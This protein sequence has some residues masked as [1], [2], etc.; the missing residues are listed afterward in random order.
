MT[1]EIELVY[2]TDAKFRDYS[3]DQHLRAAVCH[4]QAV[5][6][7]CR[8]TANASSTNLNVAHYLEK[9]IEIAINQAKFVK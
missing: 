1:D 3:P 9:A 7:H 8:L 2:P 4:L 6:A 5:Q